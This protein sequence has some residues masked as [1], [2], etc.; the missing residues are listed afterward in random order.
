MS[1]K[2]YSRVV[3]AL[4]SVCVTAALLPGAAS[5]SPASTASADSAALQRAIARYDA[6][7]AASD[8]LSARVAAASETLDAAVAAETAA[9]KRLGARIVGIYSSDRADALAL[10]LSATSFRD[11]VTR[12]DFLDRI[13]EQDA[14]NLATLR[15]A[16][17]QA[18][19]SAENLLGLQADQAKAADALSAE[20]ASARKELASSEAALKAYQ[21]KASA[22]KPAPKKQP[23]GSGAWKSAVAS[24]YSKN[25][26]GRGASGEQIGP[27]SMIVAHKTLPFGTLI[28]FQ[29][30]GKTAVGRV[31]DRGPYVAGREFDLGPG[32]VRVLG[33]NGVHTV[34]YRIISR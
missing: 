22:P 14:E 29:Y 26:S 32:L 11:F 33:F 12:L 7:R 15:A 17:A 31:A 5:A 21:A 20:V 2:T 24:H 1:L 3:V 16:R 4:V 23:T 19:R 28:E 6:A 27:Y 13:A 34:R 30:N 10:L 9:E 18:Q 8:N 25:F